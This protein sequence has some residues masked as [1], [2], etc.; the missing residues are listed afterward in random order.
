MRIGTVTIEPGAALAPMAGA[1]DGPMRAL[2]VQQG[3][4]FTVSEMV[5]AKALTMNDHKSLRLLRGATKGAPYGVQLFGHE[6]EVLAE[7]VRRIEAE[8]F[9]FLDLNLGCPAQKVVSG[10]AGSALLKDPKKAGAFAAAAVGASHRPVSVK[11]RIGWDEKALTGTEVAK[12]CEDAGVALLAVHARTRAEQYTPGVHY[13]AAAEIKRAVSIPVLFNGDITCGADALHALAETGCDGVMIGRAAQGNPFVFREVNAALRAEPAPPPPT[14]AQ[15]MAAL[16]T[17]VR[18]MC[19]EKGEEVA[20]RAAR[21]VV[22]AYMHGL[23]GAAA[24][25][26]QAYALTR[27]SD[28]EGLLDEVYRLQ[29]RGGAG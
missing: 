25:R 11:M 19:E 5:S 21:G 10:G 17:Q 2:C 16:E 27:F 6:P 8:T 9:A 18:G 13:E 20:M 4:V 12:R 7:A 22:G 29:A 1:G 14:L 28:L 24:L 26:R 3:A 23:H 15:R